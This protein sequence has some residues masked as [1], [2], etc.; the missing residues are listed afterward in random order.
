[1]NNTILSR[2]LAVALSLFSCS[3][4][5]AADPPT[6][7]TEPTTREAV[8]A[9]LK[10]NNVG[11]DQLS[12]ETKNGGPSIGIGIRIGKTGDDAKNANDENLGLIAQLS[13][14]ERVYIY[15]GQFTK[16]GL[17]RLSA[18]P[19]LRLLVIYESPA[20]PDAY[21]A[22][23][24]LT[25]LQHLSIGEYPVTDEILGYAGR[26]RGLKAFDHTKSAITPA[27]FL[28]FL[29]AVDG[30]ESLTLFGDFVDDA[31]MKRIGQMKNMKR[32][33]VNSKKVT[34]RGWES[35]VGLT[36]MNDLNLS[37]TS[38]DDDG[39]KALEGMKGLESL[40][41]NNTPIGDKG[42]THLA[43]LVEM[44]DLGLDGT[45]ITDAGMTNLK[46]MT[47]LKNLYVGNTDVTASGLA[48][49]PRKDRMV[50]MRTG[51]A[52]LTPTQLEEVIKMY[53]GTQIFDPVGYWTP[54]RA[55][56]AMKELGKEVPVPK[57]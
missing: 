21:S 34:P 48:L 3:L 42:M 31:C 32:L 24:K 19:K 28:K 33:W 47:E 49:V 18:L 56:A 53:P 36:K 2:I 14:V 23:A 13:E 8:L 51:K 40:I 37:G 55:K 45:K 46:G 25:Q 30:M 52:R 15:K 57:K 29:E 50:M 22:L 4:T 12:I 17:A 9:K 44:H 41:L 1:M 39:A 5:W 35:L 7:P 54:E 26:I 6:K 20:E 27:G 16:V 11:T 43:G 38:L 10:A